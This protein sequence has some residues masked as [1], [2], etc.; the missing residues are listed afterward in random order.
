MPKSQSKAQSQNLKLRRGFKTEAEQIAGRCRSELSLNEWDPL[1]CFLLAKHLGL[2]VITPTDI[3]G[4]SQKSLD[5]LINGQGASH[6]SAVTIGIEK[7]ALIIYNDSH[8]APRIE[9]D[10]MHE[11]AHVLLKHPMSEIDM[12][13]GIPLRK[14]DQM[15]EMEAEWLGACLQLPAA[16]LKKYYSFGNHTAEQICALFKASTQ[17]VRYRL[18]VS[19]ATAI[20]S[21]FKR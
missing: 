8:S 15:Q 9:S 3:P 2:Q 11:A 21:R 17:M 14:Y 1:P 13:I 4:L 19:G 12:S 7:P 6:W 16:A 20:K 10:V 18:G 5:A